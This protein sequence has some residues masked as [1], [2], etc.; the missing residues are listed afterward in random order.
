M[1]ERE[2][3]VQ[4]LSA[5][6]AQRPF[7][8][9]RGPLVRVILLRVSGEDHVLLV[10]LHHIIFDGWSAEVFWREWTTLYIAICTVGSL[11]RCLSSSPVR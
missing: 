9:A 7:D 11:Y 6:E 8:L 4:R 10:T 3:A 5:E 1:T 2:A